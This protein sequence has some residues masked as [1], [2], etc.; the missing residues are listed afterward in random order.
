MNSGSFDANVLL[1]LLLN[2]IKDQHAAVLKLMRDPSATFA[3]ADVAVVE[4]VFVLER[5]YGFT[6]S[7]I[8][9][10][11]EGLCSIPQITCNQTLFQKTLPVFV[12]NMKLSFEDCCL[13]TYAEL[14]NSLPLWTFDRKLA[15]QAPGAKIVPIK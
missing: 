15:N 3:V 2:D 10:A 9:E 12:K 7:Q 5:H 1:R 6:R 14:Q 8:S 4:V 13:A 11:I